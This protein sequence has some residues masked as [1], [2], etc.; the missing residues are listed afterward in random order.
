MAIIVTFFVSC[1]WFWICK[2]ID[3]IDTKT[4]YREYD[5]SHQ[6][7]FNRLIICFY[8]IL[9]MFSTVGFGDVRAISIKEQVVCIFIMILSAGV[10]SYF[11]SIMTKE[12]RRIAE[13][14]SELTTQTFLS[15]LY[16]YN[17][18]EKFL[19]EEI[20]ENISKCENYYK[21][22]DKNFFIKENNV[23]LK[24]FPLTLRKKIFNYLWKNFYEKFST[25]FLF[26]G[27]N[28]QKYFKF[29][30]KLSF[31]IIPRKYESK[32]VLFDKGDKVSEVLFVMSGTVNVIVKHSTFMVNK[33]GDV[34][35][36]YYCLYDNECIFRYETGSRCDFF[37]IAKKDLN[38]LL[39]LFPEI[40]ENVKVNSVK[41]YRRVC[42][43][44]K[45]F[46]EHSTRGYSVVPGD[47]FRSKRRNSEEDFK[48]SRKKIIGLGKDEEIDCMKYVYLEHMDLEKKIEKKKNLRMLY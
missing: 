48:K 1:F 28:Q 34:V 38:G 24:S 20:I 47:N 15:D 12:R 7:P 40:K 26:Y 19:T 45:I 46:Q 18:A 21:K 44:S 3:K 37:A 11:I 39:K 33:S 42:K 22:R 25:F 16:H 30:Y 41:K 27:N 29:Y 9:C 14:D 4:F 5:M 6:E 31:A 32:E 13:R 23:I 43:L 10:F 2:K 36:S 17:N 8:F 35:G